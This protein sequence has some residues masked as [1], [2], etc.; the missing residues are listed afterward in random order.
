MPGCGTVSKFSCRVVEMLEELSCQ[1]ASLP[2][3]PLKRLF[4]L[5]ETRS[6]RLDQL[7]G[8]FYDHSRNIPK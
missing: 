1:Q 2:L 5:R 7:S 6:E 8:I 4:N 3:L